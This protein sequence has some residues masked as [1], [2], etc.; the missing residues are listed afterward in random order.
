[1][2]ARTLLRKP[3]KCH[4][5]EI[6]YSEPH[7]RKAKKRS[8]AKAWYLPGA[9]F[10]VPFVLRAH[11]AS[12]VTSFNATQGMECGAHASGLVRSH[13]WSSFHY[14]GAM[15]SRTER[16]RAE[17]ED[18]GAQSVPRGRWQ[19]GAQ[20]QGG[21]WNRGPNATSQDSSKVRSLEAALAAFGPEES[22]AKKLGSR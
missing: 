11:F 18:V 3:K 15:A 19:Q 1:M 9:P 16:V 6:H 8:G 22:S 7:N 12:Q 2:G 14:F 20:S 4:P 13:S 5:S 17:K 21:R 10:K